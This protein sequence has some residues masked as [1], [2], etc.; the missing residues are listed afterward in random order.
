MNIFGKE[1]IKGK[2]KAISISKEKGVKKENVETALLKEDFGIVNDAHAGDHLRQ[3]SLLAIESINKIKNK[4]PEIIP[5]AFA[6]NITTEGINLTEL[7]IG[8]KLR[9]GKNS[10]LEISQIGKKCYS[11]CRIYRMV[12]DC[13]MPREGIFAKVI[14]GG[15][16]KKGD[17]V[18]VTENAK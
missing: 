14:K 12:G 11:P 17:M 7:S 16:I 13:I 4:L 9:I 5:G 2:I 10:L 18:K 3:V 1:K 8:T 15:I 6:E